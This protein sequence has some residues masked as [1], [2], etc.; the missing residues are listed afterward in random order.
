MHPNCDVVR[1]IVRA[2]LD[3]R[4]IHPL[5]ASQERSHLRTIFDVGYNMGAAVERDLVASVPLL[6]DRAEFCG[7]IHSSSCFVVV[8]LPMVEFEPLDSFLP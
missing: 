5:P 4:N 6:V 3:F 2:G 1:S 8:E 7:S